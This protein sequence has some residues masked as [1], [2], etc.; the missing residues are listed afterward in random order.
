MT[1]AIDVLI[2]VVIVGFYVCWRTLRGIEFYV[3]RC[4]N[5][6]EKI[7]YAVSR[8]DDN[9]SGVSSMLEE[10]ENHLNPSKE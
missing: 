8:T 6:L 10:I 3:A 4:V 9:T 7:Q 2:A 1:L 5:E